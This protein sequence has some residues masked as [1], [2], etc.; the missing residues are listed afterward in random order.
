MDHVIE[1]N[2]QD[3]NKIDFA[4]EKLTVHAFVKEQ[5]VGHA[6]VDGAG[7][8]KVTF[9]SEEERPTTEL[10]VAPT[11]TTGG[12]PIAAATQKLEPVEFSRQENLVTAQKDFRVSSDILEWIRRLRLPYNMFGQVFGQT[13][14]TIEP[15]PALKMDFYECD[16]WFPFAIPL[17]TKLPP[18]V[19]D[20]GLHVPPFRFP[21]L[22]K[23]YLGTTYT[24]PNG[25]YEFNFTWNLLLGV[26]PWRWPDPKPDIQVRISQFF[27]E[28]W[29]EVFCGPVDWNI[30]PRFHRDF[31]VPAANLRA[32]PPPPP[33]TGF[34][35]SSIGLIPVDG[36]HLVNGHA[37]TD[38]MDPV[39]IMNMTQR[40]F[41]ETLRIGGL[42]A[43]TPAIASY[44]VQ[45]ASM[46]ENPL[47][48][49]D[50]LEPFHNLKWNFGNRVWDHIL[51]SPDAVTHRFTNRET[52]SNW[53]EPALKF[54]FHSRT[55]DDGFYAFRMIGF[56][57]AGNQVGNPVELPVLC[58]D[59][60]PPLA[61]LEAPAAEKCGGVLLQK[62][63]NEKG[64]TIH[65]LDLKVTAY[66][67][68][69]H[70]LNFGISATRGSK[71]FEGNVLTEILPS[72]IMS[73]P[74][75]GIRNQT[76]TVTIKELPAAFADCPTL[77]Y[78]VYLGV[79]GSATNGY[80][81]TLGSQA[82]G[83]IINLTVTKP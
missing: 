15:G 49:K 80:S 7:H 81:S 23:D 34:A 62:K 9:A 16:P 22:R 11:D 42:F 8:F 21:P 46:D 40:P 60:T 53:F 29:N 28:T 65:T 26:P 25:Y 10:R 52:E 39:P 71:P 4:K 54:T 75:N 78:S 19:P 12:L 64:E 82:V 13:T 1:G 83:R 48:W 6:N 41:G 3:G 35:F 30:V 51:F 2:L 70:V 63:L 50:V 18:L 73:T 68:A 5:E 66:D 33:A 72:I 57:T 69:K 38:A 24:D 36:K 76:E 44:K 43:K 74:G 14:F 37:Y 32:I 47:T 79:Q 67:E 31:L 77:V 45:I 20:L 59:N 17:S 55:V 61:D 27:N 58:I 56:D